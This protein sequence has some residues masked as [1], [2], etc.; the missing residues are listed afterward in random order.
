MGV[1]YQTKNRLRRKVMTAPLSA[2]PEQLRQV[3]A[4]HVARPAGMAWWPMVA[5]VAVAVTA[6]FFVYRG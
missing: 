1:S 5:A 6:F 2:P 3:D 4:A